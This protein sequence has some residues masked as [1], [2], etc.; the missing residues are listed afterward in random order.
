MQGTSSHEA[1]L[2]ITVTGWEL[3]IGLL[4]VL[5]SVLATYLPTYESMV[6][7]KIGMER[8]GG[9]R[10]VC[11]CEEAGVHSQLPFAASHPDWHWIHDASAHGLST[12][13]LHHFVN[14]SLISLAENHAMSSSSIWACMSSEPLL[15]LTG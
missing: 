4:S 5:T 1:W 11:R 6:V 10:Q 14:R 15:P 3:F 9:P 12:A 8:A 7:A 2:S 13:W